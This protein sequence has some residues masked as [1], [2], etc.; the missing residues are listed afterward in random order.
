LTGLTDKIYNYIETINDI[1]EESLP[2]HTMGAYAG[3]V[4]WVPISPERA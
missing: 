2:G 4:E 3:Y 1:I